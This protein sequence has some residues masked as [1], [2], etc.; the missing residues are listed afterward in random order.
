MIMVMVVWFVM[1]VV[2]VDGEKCNQV[3]E[4]VVQ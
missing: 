2:E 4:K 1:G 3:K